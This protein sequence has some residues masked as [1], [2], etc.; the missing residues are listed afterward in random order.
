MS[1]RIS[2]TVVVHDDTTVE[3]L[4]EWVH[5]EDEILSGKGNGIKVENVRA[6]DVLQ[7]VFASA[8]EYEVVDESMV[9][10]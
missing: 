7:Q 4:K 9:D 1:V 5:E 8:L 10:L 6:E 3:N 2:I